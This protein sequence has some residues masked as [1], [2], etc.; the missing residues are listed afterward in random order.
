MM[1]STFAAK[2]SHAQSLSLFDTAWITK[3]ADASMKAIPVHITDAIAPKSDGSIHDYYS[4][5]DYWW[6]DPETADGLPYIRRDGESNPNNFDSHR[7]VLRTART[8]IAHLAAAY[9][10]TGK[11]AY[12]FCGNFSLMKRP[13]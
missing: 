2:G 10:V 3:H 5:G 12:S 6:P 9:A 8:H 7:M 1:N 13:R 4:N 11:E